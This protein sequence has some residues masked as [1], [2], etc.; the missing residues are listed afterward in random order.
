MKRA[1]KVIGGKVNNLYSVYSDDGEML[2]YLEEYEFTDKISKGDGAVIEVV[3]GKGETNARLS[4]LLFESFNEE[5]INTHFAGV[6][7]EKNS[8]LVWK[9]A[10]F[11]LE[12]VCRNVA[13]GSFV[14]RYEGWIPEGKKF[15]IPIVEFFLKSDKINDPPI[16]TSAINALGIASMSELAQIDFLMREVN[17]VAKRFFDNLGLELIDFKCEFGIKADGSIC[18]A[19]EFSQDTC[20]LWDISGEHIDKDVFRKGKVLDEVEAVYRKMLLMLK[21]F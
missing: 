1:T 20:R 14:R 2:P 15:D 8:M 5:G 19:D 17:Q 10:M 9:C 16:Q 13:T 18:V 7:T 4:T 12:V 21:Q 6:G 11:P 3:P